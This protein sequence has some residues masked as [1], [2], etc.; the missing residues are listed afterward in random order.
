M[1]TRLFSKRDLSAALS[2]EQ[3]RI[4][5]EVTDLSEERILNTPL[6]GLL[7]Y[8]CEKYQLDMPLI[9]DEGIDIDYNETSIDVG[10]RFSYGGSRLGGPVKA[11]GT[12]YEVNVPFEGDPDLFGWQP[13]THEFDPPRAR[14]RAG[15]LVFTYNVLPSEASALQ[16]Q[17]DRDLSQLQRYLDWTASQV[18]EFNSRVRSIAEQAIESRRSFLMGVQEVAYNLR[19]P[20][21]RRADAPETYVVPEVRRKIAPKLPPIVPGRDAPTPVI[22]M[23]DYDNILSIVSNMV[24]VMERSPSAFQGMKEE[25]LRQHFLVQLNAQYEGQATAETFNATGKTDI[26]IRAEGKNIF[27]AECKF[28]RGPTDLNKALDQLLSYTTWRDTKTALLVFNRDTQMSTVLDRIPTVIEQHPSYKAAH[29]YNSETGFRYTLNHRDDPDR[30]LTL[31]VL[32]FHVPG[33]D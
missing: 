18:E 19:F 20:V 4:R 23:E 16:S 30:E 32:V 22:D 10:G 8:F 21:R 1:T 28:W 26:L 25:D 2:N 5:Q 24:A 13:S 9:D 27:I 7:D 12:K 17:I 6:D 31:T 11:A 29:N 33:S 14:I 3:G 15:C